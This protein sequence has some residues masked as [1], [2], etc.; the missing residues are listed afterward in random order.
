[1]LQNQKIK[2]AIIFL[3]TATLIVGGYL[4]FTSFSKKKKSREQ[5]KKIKRVLLVGDSQTV[6]SWSYGNKLAALLNWQIEKIAIVGK[7]TS[8]MKQQLLNK[9]LTNVDAVIIFGGGND[10]TSNKRLQAEA[11]LQEMYNYVT[12]KNKILIAI[13]PV[14]KELSS[15]HS[16]FQKSENKKL[17]DFVMGNSLP[18]IKINAT[19]INSPEYFSTDRI[20]L[21][22]EGHKK[23]AEILFQKIRENGRT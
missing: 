6:P 12:D 21:N 19:E 23:I 17:S 16:A 15:M 2:N 8:W 7:Q 13:S 11:N 1:M 4:I 10:I 22:G 3:S 9:D 14:S 5:V 18:L 20:H